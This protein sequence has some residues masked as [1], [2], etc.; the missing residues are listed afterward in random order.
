[1]GFSEIIHSGIELHRRSLKALFSDT[2]SCCVE[3]CIDNLTSL[4]AKAIFMPDDGTERQSSPHC[5]Q[6]FV[7]FFLFAALRKQNTQQWLHS[8]Y[9]NNRKNN[10]NENA[11]KFFNGLR[12]LVGRS[13]IIVEVSLP[14][15]G[16]TSLGRA[17]LP[18]DKIVVAQRRLP[19][20][21]RQPQ[22]KGA[23]SNSRY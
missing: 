13:L 19:D 10:T 23:H 16:H 3:N 4:H 11:L 22:E 21:T 8:G 6:N 20:N 12:V 17:P 2:F 1:M 15:I 18:S 7:S 5:G 9:C 14:L